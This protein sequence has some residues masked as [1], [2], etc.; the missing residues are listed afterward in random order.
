MLIRRLTR[1]I[2]SAHRTFILVRLTALI[3]GPLYRKKAVYSQVFSWS[4]L[5]LSF[6][7]R[8]RRRAVLKDPRVL[9]SRPSQTATQV[10]FRHSRL[11]PV[12]SQLADTD[13][14]WSLLAGSWSQLADAAMSLLA[15]TIAPRAAITAPRSVADLCSPF[16][17][18]HLSPFLFTVTAH[19]FKGP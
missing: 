14:Q 9:I 11:Q 19:L 6:S 15:V 3:S 12:R 2:M 17:P 4:A 8:R 16:R 7:P 10:T 1:L 5:G 18:S 13:R